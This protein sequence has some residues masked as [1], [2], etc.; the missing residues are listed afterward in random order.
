[1]TKNNKMFLFVLSVLI[2][3]VGL[4]SGCGKDEGSADAAA[5]APET[6]S[7]SSSSS[8][9]SSS[10]GDIYETFEA[11][12][13]AT[14]VGTTGYY[15]PWIVGTSIYASTIDLGLSSLIA[16][17]GSSKSVY[18]DYEGNAPAA[19][20][21]VVLGSAIY[22]V[23]SSVA[24][25]TKAYQ[26]VHLRFKT[27][28]T[29]VDSDGGLISLVWG[30]NDGANDVTKWR[31]AGFMN[32]G[33]QEYLTL[34]KFVGEDSYGCDAASADWDDGE[35]HTL[36]VEFDLNGNC[37]TAQM[38]SDTAVTADGD[39]G[40]TSLGAI[41]SE[42]NTFAV[43]GYGS[44]A[45]GGG[46]DYKNVY[47]DNINLSSSDIADMCPAL[48]STV[49]AGGLVGSWSMACAEG[50][51]MGDTQTTYEFVDA[52]TL[53]IYKT[54]YQEYT[55][56]AT[57]CTN[58][59]P[60]RQIIY[61]YTYTIGD[62]YSRGGNKINY[63][64]TSINYTTYSL[65]ALLN[66]VTECGYGDWA[67]GTAK[68][69]LGRTCTNT[70]GGSA[71]V[72]AAATLYDVIGLDSGAL[73][74]GSSASS[75]SYPNRAAT[76]SGARDALTYT[77]IPFSVITPLTSTD[78]L[79]TWTTA[80]TEGGGVGDQTTTYNF[81]SATNL[82]ITHKHFDDNVNGTT[83]CAGNVI[84]EVVYT[85]TYAFDGAHFNGATKINYTLVSISYTPSGSM[86]TYFNDNSE[87]GA[88]DWS[89]GVAKNV[90]GLT[91][92]LLGATALEEVGH[93]VYDIVGIIS[94]SMYFGSSITDSNRGKI[95]EA[96]RDALGYTSVAYTE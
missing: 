22:P 91:C 89:T 14:P 62:T 54:S 70:L 26:K 71:L 94:G 36:E 45:A 44:N 72:S 83:S 7:A 21:F 64:V 40:G 51:G 16:Y 46:M 95:T 30:H 28:G 52:T 1:M 41:S 49:S 73:K 74:F 29:M 20:N 33:G 53:R 88:T 84:S 81:S 86:A 2:A 57:S 93:G 8:S 38:D 69:V 59:Q 76:T 61:T 19:G 4:L 11:F 12:S 65:A 23:T 9:S 34:M 85:Y 47:F 80:C 31:T 6:T 35:W 63:T 18:L 50:G 17:D 10:G 68:D 78:V 87:C 55:D 43:W 56:E 15:G 58:S 32:G 25:M 75:T 79:G 13:G 66:S 37:F 77:N 96:E 90:A 92:A 39:C 48:P 5:A 82:V 67:N 3:C 27:G 24:D 42:L 60:N